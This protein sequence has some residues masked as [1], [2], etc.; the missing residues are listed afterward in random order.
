[1]KGWAKGGLASC[2]MKR[3]QGDENLNFCGVGESDA[4]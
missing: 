3:W 2:L 4:P 1:L